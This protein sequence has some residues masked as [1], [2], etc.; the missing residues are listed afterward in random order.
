MAV[1]WMRVWASSPYALMDAVQNRVMDALEASWRRLKLRPKGERANE[2]GLC[3]PIL[4]STSHAHAARQ[5][6]FTTIHARHHRSALLARA[7][8]SACPSLCPLPPRA[9]AR[10][11][12]APCHPECGWYYRLLLAPSFAGAHAELQ[13]SA[14]IPMRGAHYRAI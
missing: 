13:P 14:P 1:Q 8:G 11:V 5:A 4:Q 12:R 9:A 6:S 3:W 10:L 7:S 2:A